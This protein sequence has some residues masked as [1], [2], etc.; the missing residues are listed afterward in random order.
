MSAIGPDPAALYP[1]PGQERLIFLKNIITD[2]RIEVGDYTYYDDFDNPLSFLKNVL[3]HFP[4][5]QDRLRIGRFCM[6]ASGVKF[7]MNGGNHRVDLLSTYPFPVFGNGWETAFEA[8][9]WPDKGD[10]VIGNDV[11]IGYEALLMPGV[12]VG[13]GAIIATRAVV[14]RDVPAFA[15]VAGNPATVV[16]YRFDE[17]TVARLE[18][19]AWWE[20]DAAKITRNLAAICSRDVAALEQAR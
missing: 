11:W 16:R 15:I 4:F 7:V 9:S 1:M 20:W 6:I 5:S 13:N 3:Y 10:M 17:E 19:I 2:P 14:T 8:G 18:A 12:Q